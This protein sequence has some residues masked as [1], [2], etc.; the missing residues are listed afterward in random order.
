MFPSKARICIGALDCLAQL[1]FLIPRFLPWP[2]P[3][4]R[5]AAIS[6]IRCWQWLV[7]PG[8]PLHLNTGDCVAV[9]M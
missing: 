6:W 7:V 5:A 4:W 9:F 8:G 1:L 2:G 3:G